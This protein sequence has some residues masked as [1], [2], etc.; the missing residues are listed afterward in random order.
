[1]ARFGGKK[2]VLVTGA[3]GLIGQAVLKYLSLAKTDDNN[4]STE[5]YGLARSADK[6]KVLFDDYTDIHIIEGDIRNIDTLRQIEIPIDYV[7][8]CAALTQSRLMVQTPVDVADSIV[9]GTMN[10]LKF[11]KDKQV[12]SMVYLSSME[13]Y[14]QTEKLEVREEDLGDLDIANP[15]NCYPI[16]K[17][18][19]ESLCY[20]YYSQY[21]LPVKIARLAQ[22]FGPGTPQN[23]TRI[24]AQF[25]RSAVSG[26]DIV[27]HTIGDTVGNYIDIEDAI[28]AIMALLIRAK[29]GEIYNVANPAN[30]MTIL[31]MAELVSRH[32]AGGIINVTL[33]IPDNN[34]H[35]YPKSTY[36]KLN[37]DKMM[38][39][40]WKP[41]YSVEEM[42]KRMIGSWSIDKTM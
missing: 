35:G 16:S 28:S 38:A 5:M 13:V 9:T 27:L 29:D 32:I 12:K 41:K 17:R 25:A 19:A 42:Y 15:R 31:Q 39:L 18:M 30:C 2:S 34:V 10:V 23:D 7:I 3:T 8:H 14:G 37:A 33:D 4:E 26:K 22:T 24:F 40:D 36:W 21:G 1:M 20:S 11:A 6:A